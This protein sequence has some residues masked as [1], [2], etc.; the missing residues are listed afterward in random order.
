MKKHVLFCCCYF[1]FICVQAQWKPEGNK[2]IT[3]WAESINPEYVHQEYPRPRLVRNEWKNLNG[4]WDYEITKLGVNKPNFYKNKILV[5]FPIESS[6]SGVHKNVGKDNE[7]WYHSTFIIPKLWKGK[8]IILH[9]G[10]VDWK[11]EVWINDVYVGSHQGGYDPFSFDITSYLNNKKNQKLVVKV[12]D[13]TDEGYQ[14]RG[15]QTI[16][17]HGIWYTAVTGIWQTVWIE[18]VNSN[19]IKTVNIVSN[20]DESNISIKLISSET[21]EKDYFEVIIKDGNTIVSSVKSPV[22]FNLDVLI[23][24]AKLWSPES[25]FLYDMEINLVSNGKIV[26]SIK[27]YFAMRKISTRKDENGIFRLQLNNEDY[28][29]FGTLDQGWWPD[30]LYTAPSDDALKYDIIKTKE[31]GFNMIRKHVKVESARWYYHADKIGML[32]WQ[33]MPNGENFRFPKWQRDKFFDG[34]EFIPSSES[35][36]N[37]RSEWKKIIDFLYSNPSVV[38]WV[39]FNEAWGQFKTVEISEWT[40]IYDPSRLVNSASGGNYYRTGDIT[41]THNYPDPK[42]LF[43][44]NERVNVL[45]EYGGIGL[46]IDGHLWQPD[47]NWGYIKF[48]NSIEATDQYVSLANQLYKMIESG[49]SAAIYTQITDVEIEVNGLMTYD[50]KIVKLDLERVREINRKICNVFQ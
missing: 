38:C 15:K 7:L 35:E 22:K 46:A 44:D 9:F 25:P 27:S 5:P 16:N 4:L 28:F 1:F 29:Q 48:K 12:W 34:N 19:Y 3:K 2:I 8:N 20:V 6:L 13:P 30:G 41:D 10:G 18:P 43:F 39:P 21:L 23:N 11:S 40:K 50:R 17:P 31:L 24:N 49:F 45:G 26:D 42:M 14:P 33:D 32:V 36:D 47:K 37:F